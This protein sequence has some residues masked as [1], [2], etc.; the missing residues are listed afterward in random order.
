MNLLPMALSSILES[1]VAVQRITKFL[2]LEEINPKDVTH[3]PKESNSSLFAITI[4]GA[5]FSW[6]STAAT[7]FLSNI[8]LNIPTGK[9]VCV[10]G[11]V[12]SGKSSLLSAILGEIPRTDGSVTV[13]GS[14]G[15]VAQQA[16]I[17]NASLRQNILF[18]NHG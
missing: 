2:D 15:Y 6:D 17:Q 18:G 8:N 7:S 1:R 5:S 11:S 3:K 10:V 16:W 14:P 4:Q 9:L 12:G 13:Y